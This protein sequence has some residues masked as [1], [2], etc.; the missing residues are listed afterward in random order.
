M[1]SLF[2]GTYGKYK[3]YAN[4]IAPSAAFSIAIKS[5]HLMLRHKGASTKWVIVD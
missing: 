5:L 3:I 4:F 2:A 1:P